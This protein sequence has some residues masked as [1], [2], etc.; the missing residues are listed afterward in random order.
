MN[1]DGSRRPYVLG[2]IY[3]YVEFLDLPLLSQVTDLF[4]VGKKN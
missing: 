4:S 3:I 1:E 2:D